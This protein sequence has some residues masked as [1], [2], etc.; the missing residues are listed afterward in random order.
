[1]AELQ[2]VSGIFDGRRSLP[3]ANNVS[4]SLT[5]LPSGFWVLS[6]CTTI[7]DP[8]LQSLLNLINQ[9]PVQNC[10]IYW[11]RHPHHAVF[12]WFATVWNDQINSQWLKCLHR[13]IKPNEMLCKYVFVQR[14]EIRGGSQSFEAQVW[15]FFEF[16][17]S[18]E[19]L[20][21][22]LAKSLK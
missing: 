10:I 8:W 12:F 4:T 21:F 13:P 5:Y 22:G 11:T 1:M 3:A 7:Q 19:S 9:S 2:N 17:G 6:S 16:E 15:I 20:T 18:E 14:L